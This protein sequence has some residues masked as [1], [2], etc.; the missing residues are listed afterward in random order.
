MA[1]GGSFLDGFEEGAF[2]GAITGAITG[3][4]FAGLGQLGAALGKG[5]K[6]ASTLGKFV[7]GTAAVTIEIL[8]IQEKVLIWKCLINKVF[9]WEKRIL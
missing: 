8:F 4:A 1:R 5:I 9:T 2:S 6:C 7:K 3:A